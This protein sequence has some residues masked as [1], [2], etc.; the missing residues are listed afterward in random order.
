[1]RKE[2]GKAMSEPGDV[3]LYNITLQPAKQGIPFRRSRDGALLPYDARDYLRPR[4]RERE[5]DRERDFLPLD[6]LRYP[7]DRLRDFFPLDLLRDL[8]RDR[9][10]DLLLDLPRFPPIFSIWLPA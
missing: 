9:L 4:L 1:M 6:L 5:R 7:R 2:W 10:R 3:S 8:L